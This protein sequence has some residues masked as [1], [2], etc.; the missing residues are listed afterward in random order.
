[1]TVREQSKLVNAIGSEPGYLSR[2]PAV[3]LNAY[4]N[5]AKKDLWNF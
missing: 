5:T 4:N 3:A 1:M 2:H